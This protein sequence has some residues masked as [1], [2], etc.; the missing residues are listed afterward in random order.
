MKPIN[1]Y[2]PLFLVTLIG[3]TCAQAQSSLDVHIGASGAYAKSTGQSINTFGDGNLY[4][5]PS[6]SGVFMNLS[7]VYGEEAAFAASATA[8]RTIA[9]RF[10]ISISRPSWMT[11]PA[12]PSTRYT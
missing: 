8:H 11:L 6:L 4:S 1:Q 2:L 7:H 3:V 5:T 9:N 12:P 10:V